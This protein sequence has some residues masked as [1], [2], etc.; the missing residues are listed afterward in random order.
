MSD[1][2]NKSVTDRLL[3]C[4]LQDNTLLLDKKWRLDSKE[5]A[6]TSKFSEIMFIT[7][8]N[9]VA[10]GCRNVSVMDINEFLKPYETQYN[11][12]LDNNGDDYVGLIINI[13]NVENFESYYNEFKK[14]SLLNTYYSNKFDIS[15]FWD[16]EKSDDRNY[17]ILNQYSIKDIIDYFGKTQADIKD[18]YIYDE[19]IEEYVAGADFLETKAGLAEHPMIGSSFQSPYI[20]AIFNG[21]SGFIFRSGKSGGGKT[22]TS[23]GDM[24]KVGITHYWDDKEQA[25]VK[26]KSYEGATLIISTEMDLRR[27]LDPMLV[28]W[29]ANVDRKFI[30]RNTYESKEQERRVEEASKIVANSG[31]YLIDAPDFTLET[32][33]KKITYYVQ[34]MGVK[35][36]AF[37]YCQTQPFINKEI[38]QELSI[39][40]RE[41][42]VLLTL[43]DRL[44]TLQRKLGINLLSGTQLNGQEDNLP[45]PTECCLAGG[46]SQIRKLDGAMI[47]L[48]PKPKELEAIALLDNRIGFNNPQCNRITH[49]IKGRS[50]EYENHL[51]VCSYIDT[52]TCRC[53]D[54]CV[55]DKDN[56]PYNVKPLIIENEEVSNE[57]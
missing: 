4:L 46:K 41:D 57:Q 13:T 1:I 51:K 33:T 50:N 42:L 35:N 17:E 15:K 6:Y 34:Y 43:T 32:L 53:Y 26:N 2:C 11:I 7:I 31:M 48:P 21:M 19:N 44:K 20:N 29:T 28:A 24:C 27:E 37:D 22:I 30:R 49:I 55:L 12:Y 39:P 40:P 38:S 56:K 16:F 9:L 3:G 47:M 10:N 36:V 25:F 18:D 8:N 52:G 23:I 54:I 14:L 5:F 45:Y